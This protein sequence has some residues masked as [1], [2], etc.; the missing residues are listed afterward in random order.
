[1]LYYMNQRIGLFF[2]T[3]YS[4]SLFFGDFHDSSIRGFH[5]LFGVRFSLTGSNHPL[6]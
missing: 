2:K 3:G 4:Y 5:F 6:L 1:M